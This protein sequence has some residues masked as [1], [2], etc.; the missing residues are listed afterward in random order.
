MKL[1]IVKEEK[2]YTEII[3]DTDSILTNSSISEEVFDTANLIN[4]IR[5][6]NIDDF[7]EHN[8]S[9]SSEVTETLIRVEPVNEAL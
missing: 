2:I 5:A 7:Y 8:E 3:I 1:R 4:D 9:M 6:G